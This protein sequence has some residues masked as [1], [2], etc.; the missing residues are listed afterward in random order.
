[1]ADE[2]TE[3]TAETAPE[4]PR[5]ADQRIDNLEAK[6]D[7]ILG[8]LGRD[9]SKAH[10]AAQEHTEA[11]L[12]RPTNVADEIRA[13]LN[14]RDRQAAAE[15]DKSDLASLKETVAQLA[16]KSPEPMPRRI[17]TLMWGKR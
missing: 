14:E 3:D 8:I 15:R 4:S 12:D 17:E 5:D 13:Q 11:K 16:E 2:D 9:E 1:M 6:V 10:G 7:R